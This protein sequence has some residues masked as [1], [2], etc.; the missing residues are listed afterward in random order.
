MDCAAKS[1][2]VLCVTKFLI[3]VSRF[4][5]EIIAKLRRKDRLQS[6]ILLRNLGELDALL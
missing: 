1:F 2:D 5:R 4:L 6:D 3:I